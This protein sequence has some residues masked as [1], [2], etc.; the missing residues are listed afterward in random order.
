MAPSAGG[1][2][3]V[4]ARPAL[5]RAA[6]RAGHHHAARRVR[7][8]E[9]D[10]RGR[11]HGADRRADRGHPHLPAAFLRAVESAY[12]GTRMGREEIDEMLLP[13]VAGSLWPAELIERC[14]GAVPSADA[15][16]RVVIGVDPPASAE[17]T[18]GIVACG[19]FRAGNKS[20]LRLI[21]NIVSATAISQ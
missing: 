16:R 5:R 15:L 3:H 17:G 10:P 8:A 14:R 19:R 18:C 13:D 4:A 2:G 9:T 7:G 1:V 11:G 6:A 12:G 20:L 21:R